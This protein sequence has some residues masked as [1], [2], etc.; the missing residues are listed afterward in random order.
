MLRSLPRNDENYEHL[1]SSQKSESIRTLE[2]NTD[3]NLLQKESDNLT[4]SSPIGATHSYERKS[5]SNSHEGELA[6][7]DITRV[8][9]DLEQMP[10]DELMSLCKRYRDKVVAE[11]SR[12]DVRILQEINRVLSLRINRPSSIVEKKASSPQSESLLGPNAF[13]HKDS[14]TISMNLSILSNDSL[15]LSALNENEDELLLTKSLRKASEDSTGVT[16]QFSQGESPVLTGLKE[17]ELIPVDDDYVMER[18]DG[19]HS[20]YESFHSLE[21]KHA[22]IRRRDEGEISSKR[23]HISV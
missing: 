5:G 10:L 18:M 9:S 1:Y 19:K 2:N 14:G 11:D 20:K 3:C 16:L 4:N 22:R 21:L 15:E 13:S 17:I 6:T 7:E 8:L 23:I 12:G